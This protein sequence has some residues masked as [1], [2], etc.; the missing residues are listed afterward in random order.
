MDEFK[1]LE[2]FIGYKMP[3]SLK[4]LLS[5][6][7]YTSLLSLKMFTNENITKLEDY[8][9]ANYDSIRPDKFDEYKNMR[10]FSFLPGHREI[11][12]SLPRIINNLKV[13]LATCKLH[14]CTTFRISILKFIFFFN[15]GW[16][17]MWKFMWWLL[18]TILYSF[19]TDDRCCEE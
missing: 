6:A 19:Q 16:K 3:T 10:L 18:W 17:S 13:W 2:D 9:N 12:L 8:I 7:A 5:E 4:V 11:L 14:V 15:L 1:Q